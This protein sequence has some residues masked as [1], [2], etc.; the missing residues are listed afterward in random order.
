MKSIIGL[1]LIVAFSLSCTTISK[2]P[3][4]KGKLKSSSHVERIQ[5]LYGK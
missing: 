5:E 4:K 3:K 2:K 1:S